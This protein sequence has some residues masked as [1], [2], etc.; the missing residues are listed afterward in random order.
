ME[1]WKHIPWY[2]D[3]YYASNKWNIKT[4]NYSNRW[5]EVI[6]NPSISNSWYYVIRLTDNNWK[7]IYQT[8]HRLCMYAFKWISD[9]IVNHIDWNKL[10]NEQTNLQYCTI[11]ENALH[12]YNV[13]WNI[14]PQ[15][16]RF[17]S[18]HWA[19]KKI[20]QLDLEWN[21]IKEWWSIIEAATA[22]QINNRCISAV[23]KWK[24]NTSWWFVF[25]YII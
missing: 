18:N 15:E 17:W 8:V 25:K 14:P 3:R 6:Y 7:R 23:L 10:N 20:N 24:Q 22:L 11:S 13:L 1:E 2:P 12:S 9:L 19:S 16:W 5:T 4:T 21:F